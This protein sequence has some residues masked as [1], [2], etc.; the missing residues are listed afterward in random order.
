MQPHTV[1]NV[2]GHLTRTSTRQTWQSEPRPIEGY[3]ANGAI[4]VKIRHDDECKNGHNSFA[5]T[6]SV[7][8]GEFGRIAA[9]GCLHE[10]IAQVFPELAPLIKWHLCSTEQPLHYVANAAYLAGNLDHSRRAKGEPTAYAHSVRFGDN[11]IPHKLK[12]AFWQWLQDY[13]ASAFDQPPFDFEVIRVDHKN[14]GKPHEHQF[15]PK[16]TFGGFDV[17]WHECP[18]DDEQA[19]LDFL[20]ALQN[21][22]PRFERVPCSWSEGKERELDKARRAAIWPEAT[23]EQL[24]LPRAELEALLNARLPALMAQFKADIES[25]GFAI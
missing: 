18:F 4:V 1:H 12:T 11:P 23:D 6:A 22:S 9:G 16:F 3:G 24:C 13:K 25:I 20:Y 21:C 15:T 5:I 8:S 7:T 10:D 19:A 14:R 2:A 17:Q